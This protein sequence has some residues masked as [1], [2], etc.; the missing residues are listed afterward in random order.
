MLYHHADM[1]AERGFGAMISWVILA[2]VGVAVAMIPL[3]WL[4]NHGQMAN[5]A[6]LWWLWLSITA[7]ATIIS[8]ALVDSVSRDAGDPSALKSFM[9]YVVFSLTGAGAIWSAASWVWLH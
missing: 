4:W 7:I 8:M 9:C 3:I 2:L 5:L 6:P 1:S